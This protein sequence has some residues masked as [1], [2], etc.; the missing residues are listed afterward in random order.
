MVTVIQ[1]IVFDGNI[2]YSYCRCTVHLDSSSFFSN[3]TQLACNIYFADSPAA[4][5]EIPS[6]AELSPLSLDSPSAL[7]TGKSTPS[8][9]SPGEYN[10]CNLYVRDCGEN[11]V[12]VNMEGTALYDS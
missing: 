4:N 11:V 9:A 3:I 12:H 8:E 7:V 5:F 2:V 10:Y 6:S 1:K